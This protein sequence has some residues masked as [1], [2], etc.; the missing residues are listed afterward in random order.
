VLATLATTYEE[1]GDRA[2]ALNWLGR[3]IDAGYSIKRVERSP[4][5]KDLRAD[6]RYTPLRK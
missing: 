3:A 1:L 2:A 6:P 5:L 4:W